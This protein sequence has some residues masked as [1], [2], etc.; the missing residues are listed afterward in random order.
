MAETE[1]VDEGIDALSRA[2]RLLPSRHEVLAELIA[3]L[4]SNDRATEAR[5]LLERALRRRADDAKL[6]R[7]A[8]EAV[9]EAEFREA[10]EVHNQGNLAE[11]EAMLREVVERT[12]D[13]RL[14]ARIETRRHS[15]LGGEAPAGDAVDLY[16][17]AVATA[18][19]GD[20]ERAIEL[21][22]QL[23]ASEEAGPLRGTAQANLDEIRRIH[24][25]NRLAG[26]FNEAVGHANAG[27]RDDAIRLFEQILESDPDEELR[28]EVESILADLKRRRRRR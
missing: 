15:L 4:A 24:D 16:N 6:V 23:V 2:S 8:E 5:T 10:V 28:Q 1:G 20:L 19:R 13:P 18:N 7:Y 17:Q 26:L 12:A 11:A 9:T 25:H 14:R 21:L 22:E 27:R 3:L